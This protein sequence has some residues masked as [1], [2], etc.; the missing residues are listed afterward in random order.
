MNCV[1]KHLSAVKGGRLAQACYRAR[2]ET[3]ILSDIPGDDPALVASG[4]TFPDQSTC[5]DA[6]LVVSRYG[7][8]LNQRLVAALTR[9]GA[10]T[11][12]PGA[13]CFQNHHTHL[14]ASAQHALDAA[15]SHA[16]AGVDGAHS[17]GCD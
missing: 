12:K 7:L 9:P 3:L 14:I 8:Q 15:V 4:P 2:I 5:G 16:R 13:A 6:P 11:P 1:R 17:V 10:A